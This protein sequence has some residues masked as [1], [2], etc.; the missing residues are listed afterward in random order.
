MQAHMKP[1]IFGLLFLLSV[2]GLA[3]NQTIIDS[4]NNKLHASKEDSSVALIHYQLNKRWAEYNFDSAL[5]HADRGMMISER[6]KNSRLMA[7]GLNAYGLAFDYQNQFDSALFYYNKA[8]ELARS[9]K[10]LEECARAI[11]NKGAVYTIIGELDLALDEYAAAGEI[12]Q[13]LNL[14]VYQAKILNNQAL[15][16]RRTK[17]YEM[18][19]LVLIQAID[20]YKKHE[21]AERQ[22]NA[23]INLSGMYMQLHEYDS[24]IVIATEA[25]ELAQLLGNNDY[26][27]QAMVILGQ[28]WNELGDSEQAYQSYLK[29][30]QTLNSNTPHAI[31]VYTNMGMADYHLKK[32]N[33]Q[34][35]YPYLERLEKLELTFK[36]V[37]MAHSYYLLLS[38]YY[39]GVENWKQ[40]TEALS[41]AM[42]MKDAILD[43]KVAE[44]TTVLEQKFK[45]A[46]R[47]WEIETLETEVENKE[48]QTI[49]LSFIAVLVFLV[50]IFLIVTIRQR[51]V[52]NQLQKALLSEEIDGLRLRIGK[53]MSDVKLDEIDIDYGKLKND[54][55]NSLTD[56]EIQILQLAI[57]NKSNQEIADEIFLSVNTVKYHLKNIY[58]KLGV[59]TRLEAREALSHTN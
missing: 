13:K 25:I 52:R 27:T 22:Y 9:Q 24:A 58:A 54:I 44:R 53:I 28:S 15:I 5:F 38:Q 50:C 42:E 11:F 57:T 21:E 33:Y 23:S 45:K 36:H 16:F 8:E 41:R 10:N 49:A 48:R 40:S 55:P 43:E 12:Y 34:A 6:L 47:E 2:K 7:R 18:A 35:A 39:Q 59:S 19:K 51:Q 56:R 32:D 14:P 30:E 4:L 31:Q 17:Q 1:T 37:D 46:Q 29:A 20:I 3:Q 26:Q